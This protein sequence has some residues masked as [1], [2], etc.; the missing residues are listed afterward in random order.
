MSLVMVPSNLSPRPSHQCFCGAS[1]G[2]HYSG[3]LYTSH[4]CEPYSQVTLTWKVSSVWSAY[5]DRVYSS[6]C[7]KASCLGTGI[8]SSSSKQMGE[9]GFCGGVEREEASR[10]NSHLPWKM[11]S[12][13][14]FQ[15]QWV[16]S[17][18]MKPCHLETLCGHQG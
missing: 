13:W 1:K 16:I 12:S 4:I 10:V 6:S 8:E 3:V 5:V 17:L 11:R 18:C 2:G 7:G 14:S 15:K 9:P